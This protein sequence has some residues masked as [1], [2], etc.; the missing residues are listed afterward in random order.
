M[1]RRNIRIVFVSIPDGKEWPVESMIGGDFGTPETETEAIKTAGQFLLDCFERE[2]ARRHFLPWRR[3]KKPD[4][5]RM[6]R[7]EAI[8]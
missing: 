8:P 6:D 4:S 2:A 3:F 5:I 7:I 1:S